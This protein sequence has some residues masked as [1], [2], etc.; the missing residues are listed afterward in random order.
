MNLENHVCVCVL[1]AGGGGGQF[2]IQKHGGRPPSCTNPHSICT[3]G[4]GAIP[5]PA[6]FQPATGGW[7]AE[8]GAP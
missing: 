2:N 5:L 7:P 6:T 8:D 1:G 4:A 3:V